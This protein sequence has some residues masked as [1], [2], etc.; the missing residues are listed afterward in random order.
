M[1]TSKIRDIALSLII[2]I[3]LGFIIHWLNSSGDKKGEKGGHSFEKVIR[4][5]AK[6]I[7]ADSFFI[8]K[9]EIRLFGVDAPEGKQQCE[10]ADEKDY[11]CGRASSKA[12]RKFVK[13]KSLEC[14]VRTQDRYDRAISICYVDKMDLNE[15]LVRR[16]WAVAYRKYSR[17]YVRAE[18]LAKQDGLGIWQGNFLEPS[19]WRHIHNSH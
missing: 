15:W 12:L 18:N 17:N 13:N 5:H 4:G 8:G 11:A 14:H 10:T 3:C 9:S 1:H 6:I 7:D 2:V 19:Q 16:G